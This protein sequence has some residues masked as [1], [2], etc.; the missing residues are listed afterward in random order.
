MAQL[1]ECAQKEFM[2]GRDDDQVI[3][4]TEDVGEV[5]TD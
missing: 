3:E 1:E 4:E 5:S 2:Y